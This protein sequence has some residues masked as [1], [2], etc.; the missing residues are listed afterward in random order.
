M[1]NVNFVHKDVQRILSS[2]KISEKYNEQEVF[3]KKKL[4]LKISQYSQ[5]NTCFGVSFFNKN[6]GLQACNFI[7]KRLQHWC[8]LGNAAKFLSTAI[9]KNIC[10]RLLLRVFSFYVS[11]N[12]FLH[13]QITQQATY[14]VKKT[15]PQKQNK[16]Y[17]SKTQLDKKIPFHEE[18]LYHLVF[19]YF[20]THVRQCLPYIKH[21]K[22]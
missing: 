15:F 13:E 18:H 5:E 9:L 1:K 10:K 19:L 11:F 17:H 7:K 4:L 6:A 2:H 14:K 8:F 22:R 12:V 20:T 3:Y 21:N 16:K